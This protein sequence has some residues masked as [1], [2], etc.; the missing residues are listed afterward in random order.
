L[1][2]TITLYIYP[3]MINKILNFI[4]AQ[5]PEI[6]VQTPS[7]INLI[8]PLDAVEGDFWMPAV[9]I[10]GLENPLSVFLFIKSSKNESLIKFFSIPKNVDEYHIQI[11]K[12]EPISKDI[13]EVKKKFNDDFKLFYGSIY[14]FYKTS[15]SFWEKFVKMNFEVGIITTIP[16]QSGLG[17]SASMIIAILYGFA[18]YFGLYNEFS[19]V[20]KEDFP[21]NKDIIAEMATK[22]EDDD[23]KITAGYGDR[24][25]ITKG[26][27]LFCSYFGKLHH[28]QLSKE[29]LAICERIDKTYNIKNLPIIICYSGILHESGNVHEKL[30][31]LYLSKEPRIIK[32]YDRLAIISWRSRF[33][34]MKHNWKQLGGLFKENTKIMNEIMK[35]A[36]Y[37]H[38][39]GLGNNILIN[40]IEDHP[41]VYAVKLTGAGG[42]GSVFALVK[43]KK[44]DIV[45]NDWQ[46]KLFD[47]TKND[48]LFLS[49]FP[50]YPVDIIE[51]LMSAQFFKIKIADGVK[52]I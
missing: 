43:P 18:N 45:L 37:K 27:L 15:S 33:C 16:R 11:E 31:K 17:G 14:R 19:C 9:A 32:N 23:L 49:L 10:N 52:L 12:E 39:I 3:I 34:L 7:R 6:V 25:V 29:P 42:G 2:D 28:K 50:T 1:L 36:G 44:I 8:N 26:G 22:V 20:S 21:I 30:R 38:G 24:Y 41:D 47:I 48:K 35:N 51:S 4:K 13:L 5:K 40:L 46:K